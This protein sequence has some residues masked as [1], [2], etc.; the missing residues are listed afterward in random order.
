MRALAFKKYF[1]FV[2]IEYNP[3]ENLF[4]QALIKIAWH[5]GKINTS[6]YFGRITDKN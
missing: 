5:T 2:F 1:N 6:G 4:A 3:S